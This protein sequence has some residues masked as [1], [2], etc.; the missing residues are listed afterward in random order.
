MENGLCR[1]GNELG[2]SSWADENVTSLFKD[3]KFDLFI[4]AYGMNDG[5]L[6]VDGAE[7]QKY[8]RGIMDKVLAM[9]PECEFILISTTLP[10]ADS[11]FMKYVSE[12]VSYHES[13][14]PLLQELADEYGENTDLFKLTSM[15]KHI[16]T[17]KLFRDATSSNINHPNDFI[18]RFYAQGIFEL[19]NQED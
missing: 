11:T 17:R 2:V 13:Y 4:I 1:G 8:I 16:L 3:D 9:N 6:K 10:N 15:H 14:E 18:I 5:T 12:G 19:L 7:Y